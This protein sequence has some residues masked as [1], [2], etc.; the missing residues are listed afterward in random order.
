MTS[1][2]VSPEQILGGLFLDADW[3]ALPLETQ[4]AIIPHLETVPARLSALLDQPANLQ[5]ILTSQ[6]N[7]MGIFPGSD[8]NLEQIEELLE[9]LSAGLISDEEERRLLIEC[10]GLKGLALKLFDMDRLFIAD[11]LKLK[12]NAILNIKGEKPA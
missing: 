10:A 6:I 4:T 8:D 1:T 3:L 11:L 9:S 7:L 2:T 12:P 5:N